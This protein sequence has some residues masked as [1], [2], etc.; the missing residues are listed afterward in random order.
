MSKEKGHISSMVKFPNR[1]KVDVHNF[2]RTETI[3]DI[4]QGCETLFAIKWMTL[5]NEGAPINITESNR[6]QIHYT[7]V[8]PVA[9][10]CPSQESLDRQP[11][12]G[13]KD[14]RCHRNGLRRRSR[15]V[16]WCSARPLDY[17]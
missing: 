13:M 2:H 11:W 16:H 1:Q 4:T 9:S 10:C 14:P 12:M 6:T 17:G 7:A 15:P 5:P 8:S 3:L